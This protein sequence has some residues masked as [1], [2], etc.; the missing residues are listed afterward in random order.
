[1][2]RNG[3]ARWVSLALGLVAGLYA[4]LLSLRPLRDPDLFWHLAVGRYVAARRALPTQNLWSYTAPDHPFLASSWLYDLWLHGLERLG[5][6]PLLQI[7]AALTVGFA[8]ALVFAAVRAR[9]ARPEFALAIS[10]AFATASEAR[11]T[12]RPQTASYLLLAALVLL[13]T[14]ARER[15]RRGALLAIPLLLCLWANMH[16][17][18]VFGLAYLACEV[19]G[20]L[21]GDLRGGL[22]ERLADVRWAPW[23][24]LGGASVA[25]LLVTPHSLG[26]LRYATFHLSDVNEVVQLG[27]FTRPTL[28]LAALFWVT[29]VLGP[30]LF[31]SQRRRMR[32][33][34]WLTF[35]G[36]SVLAIRAVRVVPEFFI[37]VAPAVGWALQSAVDGVADI[38]RRWL[39]RWA[40]PVVA[41]GLALS[42]APFPWW[43]VFARA[44]LGVDPWHVPL[45]ALERVRTWGIQG[46]C[47]A[48]WDVSGLVEW[49]APESPVQIDPRVL[50][51]PPEVFRALQEAESSPEAFERLVDRYDIQWAFRSQRFLHL[52]GAGMFRPERWATVYWDE[53][54]LI[55]LRRDVPRFQSLIEREE[56]RAF[57]PSTP[58]LDRWNRL[59]GADRDRWI[60][61]A[62]R[63]AAVSPR[64][65]SPRVAL[66]LE[67][68]RAGQPVLALSELR[69]A[70]ASARDLF[71][72][73][74]QRDGTRS[75]LTAVALAIVAQRLAREGD[76]GEAQRALE[77]ALSLAPASAEVWTGVGY[78]WLPKYP[79]RAESAFRHALNLRGD[80]APALE[81]LSRAQ[82]RANP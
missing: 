50:A 4:T 80:H 35:A 26:L 64:L 28:E 78:T 74:P 51:Y 11:F 60:Q 49:G 27:E 23:A 33:A 7:A 20:A 70:S 47:F 52:V 45:A 17:G 38:H 73:H 9:G 41:L 71:R 31:W 13:V 55:L 37:V 14:R 58:V 65:I 57:L 22:R 54:G 1:V 21:A 6:F 5:G 81:G 53:S 44:Q 10:L 32:L 56:F 34:E 30:V 46:R 43:H 2:S 12:P 24:A 29:V 61:E 3:Q 79:G 8:F 67:S 82:A 76:E 48:G 25:A 68:L 39:F 63:L 75:N 19:A 15:K 59:Q 66:A 16:A 72:I 18:V 42:V 62:Q 77:E 36:F 69:R 40:T